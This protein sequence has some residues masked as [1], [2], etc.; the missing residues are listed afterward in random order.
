MVECLV[1]ERPARKPTHPGIVLRSQVFPA[2]DLK[3][4]EAAKLLGVSRQTLHGILRESGPKPITVAMALRIG[5][6]CGNGPNLWLNMQRNY[7]LWHEGKALARE[8]NKIPTM[9]ESA[10][11]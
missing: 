4:N 1:S 3:I 8:I 11:A 5:K 2:L 6:L 10:M 7:D 9:H